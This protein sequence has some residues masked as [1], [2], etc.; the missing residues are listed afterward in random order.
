MDKSVL[1]N[2][3]LQINLRQHQNYK[4]Y[5]LKKLNSIFV[6]DSRKGFTLIEMIVVVIIVGILAAIAAPSWVSFINQRRANVVNDAVLQALRQAQSEAKKNKRDY[7]VSF[8]TT[9][10]T[11]QVA[12][13]LSGNT[14]IWE[15]LAKESSIKAGQVL[16]GT[17]ITTIT[18][19]SGKAT[20]TTG[21]SITYGSTAAQTITF[22]YIGSHSITTSSNPVIEVGIPS[23]STYTQV[24]AP[25]RRCV[26][27]VTLLG[28]MQTQQKN[29][30]NPVS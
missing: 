11:P 5:W 10:Q 12:I 13:Y 29:K 16:L 30:C 17:N 19:I 9:S 8:R 7:N 24:L 4:I 22:N 26:R 20:S 3:L 1:S 2:K 18:D 28:S 23:S 15:N 6:K 27:I 21:T 25:T 14:P